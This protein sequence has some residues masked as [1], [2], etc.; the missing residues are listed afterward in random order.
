MH[1]KLEGD[2]L[3]WQSGQQGKQPL[4]VEGEK[5]LSSAKRILIVDDDPDIAFTFKK[6]FKE[7]NRISKEVSFYS[8]HIM[9]L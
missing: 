4:E 9:I 6:A 1:N 3:R 7:A 8:T 5:P 2:L